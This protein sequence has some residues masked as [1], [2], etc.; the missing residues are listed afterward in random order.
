MDDALDEG[1]F[2]SGFDGDSALA[3]PLQYSS[4]RKTL[5]SGCFRG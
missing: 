1:G 2:E 4:L 3:D 5:V